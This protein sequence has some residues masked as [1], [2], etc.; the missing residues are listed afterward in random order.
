MESESLYLAW[1]HIESID[2]SEGSSWAGSVLASIVL[3]RSQL[4]C[5]CVQ[6]TREEYKTQEQPGMSQRSSASSMNG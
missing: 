5:K 2:F 1:S 3:R 4:K 6:S